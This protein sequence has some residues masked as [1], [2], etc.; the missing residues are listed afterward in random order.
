M[1][2]K[3][4]L[5]RAGALRSAAQMSSYEIPLGFDALNVVICSG[6]FNLNTRVRAMD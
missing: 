2:F 3:V 4:G 6:F 5:F 1:K